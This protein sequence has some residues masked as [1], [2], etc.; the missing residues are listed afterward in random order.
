[1]KINVTTS[2]ETTMLTTILTTMLTTI[3]NDI[4]HHPRGKWKLR[5]PFS[6]GERTMPKIA[7]HPYAPCVSIRARAE[8]PP[9]VPPVATIH[10][11]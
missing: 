10:H 6:E 4:N 8:S 3:L 2:V 7:W 5:N 1:M 9:G 11:R